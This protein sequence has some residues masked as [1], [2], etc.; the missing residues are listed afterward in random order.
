[1]YNVDI[2]EIINAN[3]IP[4]TCRIK[5]GQTIFIPGRRNPRPQAIVLN[6]EDFCWPLKGKVISAYGQMTGNALNRGID[7]LAAANANVVASRSGRVV[8][9]SPEFE[10]LGKTIIIEHPDGYSTL[11]ARNSEVFVTAGDQISKGMVI[12]KVGSAGRDKAAYL[13]FELRKGYLPQNP[14]FYLP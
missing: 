4:D 6:E 1:M 7:I 13:H 3:R 5:T 8:F 9:Y 14:S 10:N 2:V 12:A 11:Y